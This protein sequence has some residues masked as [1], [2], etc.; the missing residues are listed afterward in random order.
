MLA[1]LPELENQWSDAR[2]ELK[3]SDSELK[4]LQNEFSALKRQKNN[5]TGRIAEIR[6]EIVDYCGVSEE[7]IP[8]IGE[9]IQ[10]KESEASWE[11]SIEKLLQSY[12]LRL[13]VPEEY[14]EKVNHYVNNTNLRGR[15]VYQKVSEKEL[16][17]ED[18]AYDFE[19]SVFSKIEIKHDSQ[20]HE[21][22]S[23]RIKSDFDYL[24]TDDMEQFTSSRRA[25]TSE[26]LI[27]NNNRHEKDDRSKNASRER[28]VLGWDN[29]SKINHMQRLLADSES[30]KARKENELH[31]IKSKIDKLHEE[32]DAINLFLQFDKFE[33]IDWP[34]IAVEISELEQNKRNLEKSNNHV[35]EIGRAHV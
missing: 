25:V 5:I 15:I 20:F 10:V 30:R 6:S 22:L 21:W 35:E 18:Y 8:F 33:D 32:R 34:Q 26:G 28:Y 24:C 14:Y 13:I 29:S 1:E 23:T 17:A 31:L 27:K 16:N 11:Y 12:A 19:N 4:D 2:S 3:R 7:D 9:L